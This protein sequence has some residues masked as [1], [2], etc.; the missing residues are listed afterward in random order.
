MGCTTCAAAHDDLHCAP[1]PAPAPTRRGGI[2]VESLGIGVR[3]AIDKRRHHVQPVVGRIADHVELVQAYRAGVFDDRLCWT[4]HRRDPVGQLLGIRYR[5]RQADE[6]HR[7]RQV[8]DHLFPHRAAIRV[9]QKVD[10]VEHHDAERVEGIRAGVDH[11]PKHLGGHHHHRRLAIDRVVAGQQPN[12]LRS[13]QA[14]ELGVLLIRQRLDRS[15]VERPLPGGERQRNA[16]F[17]DDGLS[18]PGGRGD[19]HGVAYIEAVHRLALKA[20]ELEGISLGEP[21][22]RRAISR[23]P[24]IVRTAAHRR[25]LDLPIHSAAAAASR[26]RVM[27]RPINAAMK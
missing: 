12:A 13:V 27:R 22:P 24:F 19:E 11:V 23:H 25:V 9:L 26:R 21:T 3:S 5:R 20:V 14:D 10:L 17:G 1:R 8:D 2:V 6:Q 18:R 16:V 15:G 7:C 4:A